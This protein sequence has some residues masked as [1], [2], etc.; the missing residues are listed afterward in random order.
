M[1]AQHNKILTLINVEEPI[2][3]IIASTINLA[4]TFQ[5]EV[6]FLYVGKPADPTRTENQMEVVRSMNHRRN[7][8]ARFKIMVKRARQAEGLE[9]DYA[10]LDGPVKKTIQNS[11]LAYQPDMVVV[12]KRLPSTMRLI[13]TQVTEFVLKQFQG[14]VLIA[15]PTKVLEIKEDLSVGVLDDLATIQENDVSNALIEHTKQPVK[16][17]TIADGDKASKVEE[18]QPMPV[19][20]FK[21]QNNQNAMKNLT[22]Y[23]HRNNV[24]LLCLG[25]KAEGRTN[26]NVIIREA[27]KRVNTSMLMVGKNG[28]NLI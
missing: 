14:P 7:A 6:K 23:V 21:F 2:D 13:G 1:K 24:H 11:L 17:F 18:A 12:G 15:H 20:S 25:R 9:L 3:T 8:V 26:K 19:V 22:S 28:S 5:A 27:M 16:L 10:I 4:R